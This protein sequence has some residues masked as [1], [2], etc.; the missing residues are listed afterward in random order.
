M[1]EADPT[2]GE[3]VPAA[4]LSV[5]IHPIVVFSVLDHYIRRQEGQERVIGTLLGS[6]DPET[7]VVEVTN[8]YAVPHTETGGEVAVGQ[9]FNKNMFDLLSRVNASE[10]IV[11]WYAT[12]AADGARVDGVSSLVHKYYSMEAAPAVHVVVDPR[13]EG[14]AGVVVTAFEGTEVEDPGED[15]DAYAFA[16]LPSAL[17][18]DEGEKLCIDRMIRGQKDPWSSAEMLADVMAPDDD[19][20]QADVDELVEGVDEVIDYVAAQQ[21]AGKPIDP[22][23]ARA[24]AEAV[25]T[26]P[27]IDRAVTEG[28]LQAET[29]DVLMVS[30]LASITKAQLAIT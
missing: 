17:E 10:Q 5:K 12:N 14:D 15:G 24:M 2:E 23:C 8:A 6:F 20:A 4:P 1:A 21:K 3:E 9:Q 25:A 19:T 18:F 29:Q 13:L 30:Y 27:K 28:S 16:E 26:L 22:K 11:G 7:G